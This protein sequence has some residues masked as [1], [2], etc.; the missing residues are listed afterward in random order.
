MKRYKKLFEDIPKADAYWI[1]PNGKILPLDGNE[2]HIEKVVANPYAYGANPEEIQAI[3]TSEGENV[4]DEGKAR[5]KIILA[6]LREGWIRIRY[7]SRDD[8]Y[9]VNIFRMTKKV[10]DYLQRWASGMVDNGKKYS[11]VILDFPDKKMSHSIM[12]LS[13]DALYNEERQVSKKTLDV[14]T[15]FDPKEAPRIYLK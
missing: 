11:Q 12:E 13:Q 9:S 15:E 5:E 3:Y 4:E 8:H 7:Y 2:K 1:S 10:K 6:L 14:V